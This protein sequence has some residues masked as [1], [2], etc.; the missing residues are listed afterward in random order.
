MIRAYVRH[1]AGM[2][3]EE[4]AA[5]VEKTGVFTGFYAQNPVN[6]ALIPIWVADYV[7]MDYGTGAIMA[8]PAHDER[9]FA[10]AE[11]FGL[12]VVQVVAPAAG[13]GA[14]ADGAYVS[15]SDDDV[16]VNS[17]RFSGLS[18]PEAKAAVVGWLT[19]EGRGAQ[20]VSYRL[21]DWL[22]S[23]QR[24]WGCPIPIVH[25]P[26]CG[27]VPVPEDQLPVLLP[28]VEDYLPKGR[29]PL[30]AAEDWVATD[31]PSRRCG[32]RG[33][34][35]RPTRWTPSSTRPGTSCATPTRATT[36]RP[37]RASS[38][39]TGSRSTSTSAASS[40][41]SSTPDVRALLHEGAPRPRPRRLPR[42]RSRG[43]STRG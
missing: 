30:A 15:H 7:L 27:V 42:A 29:S 14:A 36:P 21:R 34:A 5:A 20:A 37:S 40:T 23:R 13:R 8:V 33:A 35:E 2:K 3:S 6:D 32:G 16:L 43:S 28:D 9:D 22:L 24:Y 10:F 17:G 31:L 41:R 39:T 38:S 19:A 1:A 4:R 25:C 12:P 11:R 18:S 26:A